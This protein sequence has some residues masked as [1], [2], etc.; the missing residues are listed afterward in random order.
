MKQVT[1]ILLCAGDSRR[2]GFHKLLYTLPNG[3]TPLMMSVEALVKGGVNRLII[4]SNESTRP[5]AESFVSRA[6]VPVTLCEGGETRQESVYNGL[7]LVEDGIVVVH[8]AARCMA[9]PNLVHNCIDSARLHGSGVAAIPVRDTVLHVLQDGESVNLLPREEL[10]HTQTPQAFDCRSYREAHELARR[11]N[12]LTT[13][14]SSLYAAAGHKVRF[15]RG[16]LNNRK[17]TTPDDIAWL[18]EHL[19][20]TAAGLHKQTGLRVGMGEDMHLL[21]PNRRLILGGV[22]IPHEL[23]LMGHS[24]ADVITHA[25]MDAMLGA[26]GLGDIGMQFPDTDPAYKDISSILLL[27]KTVERVE[28]AGYGVRNV[29]ITLVAQRPRVSRY[30]PDMRAELSHALGIAPDCVGL[31]ATTTEGA[32]PEGRGECMR[33]SA[34]A[35]LYTLGHL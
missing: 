29:D 35:L 22:D 2:M 24:D 15:V 33:A 9:F 3:K 17:L 27:E 11:E 32:G 7:S 4:V 5:Q 14:D 26:A 1:G 20:S 8:D 25:L 6:G 12:R 16:H 28:A 18:E 34:V 13:D 21:V 23:G 30:F 10:V 31:K 19:C